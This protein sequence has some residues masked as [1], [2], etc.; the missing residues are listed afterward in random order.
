MKKN[1]IIK[2]MLIIF[3]IGILLCLVILFAGG[4][5]L[6]KQASKEINYNSKQIWLKEQTEFLGMLS[7]AF[8]QEEMINLKAVVDKRAFDISKEMFV[9]KF[10]S[11]IDIWQD[12]LQFFYSILC[13]AKRTDRKIM[14]TINERCVKL[15]IRLLTVPPL[16][17]YKI[18]YGEDKIPPYFFPSSNRSEFFTSIENQPD[19]VIDFAIK[20]LNNEIFQFSEIMQ[21]LTYYWQNGTK[22]IFL[23]SDKYPAAEFHRGVKLFYTMTGWEEIKY[24]ICFPQ[25]SEFAFNNW[26]TI[27]GE[28]KLWS[29][30]WIKKDFGIINVNM[31]Y[32]SEDAGCV[33]IL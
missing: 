29:S 4:H 30:Y 15:R 7:N 3:L 10:N 16:T 18:E 13:Q 6:F 21:P 14:G 12:E 8:L 2:L 27:S 20:D 11:D 17:K 31:F 9:E 24:D 32:I 5:Y 19:D 28:Q 22:T 1:N 33:V 25:M 23:I 26:Y